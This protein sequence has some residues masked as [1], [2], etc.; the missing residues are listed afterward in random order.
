MLS[1]QFISYFFKP[2]PKNLSYATAPNQQYNKNSQKI[3]NLKM[4]SH[5][6]HKKKLLS[7]T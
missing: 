7:T 6:Q 4:F 5:K 3:L 2:K 1:A